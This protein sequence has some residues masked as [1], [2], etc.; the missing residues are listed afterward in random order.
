MTGVI[1]ALGQ[2]LP[3]FTGGP[4][5]PQVHRWSPSSDKIFLVASIIAADSCNFI[6]NDWCYLCFGPVPP[7]VH[8]SLHI[9]SWDDWWEDPYLG[10]SDVLCDQRGVHFGCTDREEAFS[11][12]MRLDAISKAWK[13][14]CL[15]S[16]TDL[17]IPVVCFSIGC[18]LG[19]GFCFSGRIHPACGWLCT[20]HQHITGQTMSSI[21]LLHRRPQFS[22]H[23]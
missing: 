23:D 9:L 4:V 2:S 15:P 14:I 6:N 7:Q 1:C 21:L 20:N 10:S 12:P 19:E 8:C 11:K 5:P 17:G 16:S 22:S 13:C 18:L 3:K